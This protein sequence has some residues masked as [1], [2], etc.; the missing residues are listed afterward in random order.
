VA[1]VHPGYGFLSE[2]FYF[3]DKVESMGV[4]FLGPPSSALIAMGD[5]I[6][7]KKLARSAGV[8]CCAGGLPLQWALGWG[9]RSA[10][11]V[12]SQ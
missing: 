4:K 10:V 8:R 9:G 11:C 5:K 2:K 12:A 7:S 6:E 1:Q 3:A